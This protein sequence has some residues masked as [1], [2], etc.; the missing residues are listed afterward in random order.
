ME[1]AKLS[2]GMKLVDG[3]ELKMFPSW[4]NQRSEITP[5]FS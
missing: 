4:A 2:E 5:P 1:Q 3:P